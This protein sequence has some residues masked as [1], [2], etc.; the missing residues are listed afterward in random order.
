[1]FDGGWIGD[2]IRFAHL[3][4]RFKRGGGD[5]PGVNEENAWYV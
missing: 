4:F 5:R 1:M 2:G 3:P